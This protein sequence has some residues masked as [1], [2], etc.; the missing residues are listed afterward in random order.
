MQRCF[1]EIADP[2]TDHVL[3][4][5]VNGVVNSSLEQRRTAA[6]LFTWRIT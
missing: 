3:T 1:I 5:G 6:T 4:P 2:D